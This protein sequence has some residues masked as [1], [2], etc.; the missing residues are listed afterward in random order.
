[1]SEFKK[2]WKTQCPPEDPFIVVN[3]EDA[4]ITAL[5][6]VLSKQVQIDWRFSNVILPKDIEQELKEIKNEK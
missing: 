4:W 6:W 1:M 2:W 3:V 5:K